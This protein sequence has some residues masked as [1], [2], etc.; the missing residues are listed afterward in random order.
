MEDEGKAGISRTMRRAERIEDE[1]G[2]A[3]LERR[4]P[5]LVRGEGVGGV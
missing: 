1:S 5:I 2:M 4:G 3:I